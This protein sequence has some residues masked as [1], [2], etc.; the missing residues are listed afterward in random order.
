MENVLYRHSFIYFV[1]V[2]FISRSLCIDAGDKACTRARKPGRMQ[3]RQTEIDRGTLSTTATVGTYS[4][5]HLYH[6][7]PVATVGQGCWFSFFPVVYRFR[8]RAWPLAR[9]HRFPAIIVAGW[10]KGKRRKGG[11]CRWPRSLSVLNIYG[12][13]IPR[14]L[15][16]VAS[17]ENG[18]ARVSLGIS[19]N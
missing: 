19:R 15:P 2:F 7:R 17:H 12:R 16:L 8:L 3:D 5:G 14:P 4:H 18:I 11:R 9:V 1:H 6:P 13:G 10:K